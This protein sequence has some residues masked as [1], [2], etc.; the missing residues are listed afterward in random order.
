MG[1]ERADR[2]DPYDFRWRRGQPSVGPGRTWGLLPHAP[3]KDDG[4][5][6]LL[7]TE[8]RGVTAGARVGPGSPPDR[9][10]LARRSPRRQSRRGPE[11]RRRERCHA[12][13]HHAELLRRA[14]K[15]DG[16]REEVA[17]YL[18]PKIPLKMSVQACR[19]IPGLR[20]FRQSA[21]APK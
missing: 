20:L 4:G 15:T 8:T 18:G 6:A 21:S 11:V 9:V 7:E 13:R 10:S 3:G 12:L 16:R 19:T 14:E 1:R 17:G 2:R 5:F